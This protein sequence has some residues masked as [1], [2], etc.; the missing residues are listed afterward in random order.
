MKPLSVITRILKQDPL[1]LPR[2]IITRSLYTLRTGY[3]HSGERCCPDFPDEI[4]ANQLKVYK[5]AAQ[6]CRGLRVL[7]IGCGT[8]YGTAHL[9]QIARLTVGIDLSRQAIRY[10]CEHYSGSNLQYL[11]MNVESLAFP[12]GSFDFAISTENFEHLCDHGAHLREVARV[13][14]P[15][16]LLLLATPNPE[17]FVE[18]HNPYHTHEFSYMELLEIIGRYFGEV[19]I[20]E[21]LVDPPTQTG[22]SAREDRKK[23]GQ[24]GIHLLSNPVLWEIPIETTWL[25]NTHSF[26]CFARKPLVED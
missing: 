15:R 25:S 3:Y 6:F 26:F 22:L 17:M 20:S 10:A 2:K 23:R 18:T 14:G 5:F 8:G 16:G 9:S 19:V 12:D 13:L 4:F 7:D 1:I 11:K 21:N 24:I